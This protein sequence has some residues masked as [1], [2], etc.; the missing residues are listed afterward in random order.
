MALR[1]AVAAAA[2]IGLAAA[3]AAAAA[4]S[5]PQA[6]D[7][8]ADYTKT[9]EIRRCV[10][11]LEIRQSRV[12]DVSTIL[13]RL[14]VRDEYAN[15]LGHPCPGLQVRQTFGYELRGGSE[16]CRGDIIRVLEPAGGGAACILGSFQPVAK[17]PAQPSTP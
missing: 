14:G 5:P 4:E 1:R 13:F 7:A 17:K 12:L 3:L 6:S 16:L 9:G 8:L 2:S 11:S 10:P 15:L